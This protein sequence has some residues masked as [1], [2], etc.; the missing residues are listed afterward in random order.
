MAPRI[1]PTRIGISGTGFIASG[2]ARLLRKR[3]DLPVTAVL[4]RRPMNRRRVEE[5][6]HALTTSIDELVARSDLIIECSGD[7]DLACAVVDAAFDAGLPVVTMNAEFQV[8]AG[9][10]FVGRGRMSEAAGDQ[11][12][13]LAALSEEIRTMG[14][15]PLVYGSR[16]GFLNLNP[17]PETMMHWAE[18][19]G[20]SLRRVV[21]FT[22]GTKVQIEHALVANGLGAD[23]A[24]SGLLG[25]QRN[26]LGDGAV[27]LAAAARTL[28]RAV[29]DYVLAPGGSG[30]VFIV[31]SHAD[32]HADALRYLKL[33]AGPDYL[34]VRPF[35]LAY[36]EI[37][38]T[39][40]R[41]RAGRPALLDNG[42]FPRI[43][44]AA[45][46]KRPLKRGEILP[47]GVGS[48]DVR[49]IAVPIADYPDHIPIGL[50]RD[51]EVL[52]SVE[53]GQMLTAD[54]IVVPETAAGA[55]W[56]MILAGSRIAYPASP[57]RP[58]RAAV[59]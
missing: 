26:S 53:P 21:S 15:T 59:A 35:H 29:S 2:L 52:H 54:D 24:T 4:T 36:F 5:F 58:D 10:R 28:G 9:S 37:V 11:P 31:A 8:T 12:G 25:P 56:A 44:V 39:I 14:F 7:V 18:R 22:D 46:A 30:E 20:I 55:A 45:V 13:C 42:L 51:C 48:F 3:N 27:T 6:R 49:G 33:G 50:I 17:E 1:G 40:D 43:G 41:V 16:K 23:I 57:T 38:S 32:E 34:I 47:F 19:Q